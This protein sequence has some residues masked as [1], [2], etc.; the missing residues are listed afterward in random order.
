M[1]IID[2][3]V[4]IASL[5]PS[6]KL[7]KKAYKHLQSVL[8]EDDVWVPSFV[9]LE[10]DLTLKSKNFSEEE[11]SRFF[12]KLDQIIPKNKILPV[13]PRILKRAAY[14]KDNVEYFDSLIA[15]I[16]LE[17]GAE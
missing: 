13:T 12:E 3:M 8:L 7:Y 2:T 9:L 6:H 14:M 4:I 1:R 16:A 10:F 11:R 15:S 17:Y 5:N